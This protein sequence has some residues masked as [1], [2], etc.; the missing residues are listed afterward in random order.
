MLP[1]TARRRLLHGVEIGFRLGR[2]VGADRALTP[3]ARAS[4]CSAII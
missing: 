3:S 1:N 2:L 4:G